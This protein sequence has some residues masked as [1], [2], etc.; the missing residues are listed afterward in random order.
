MPTSTPIASTKAA[1]CVATSRRALRDR[2]PLT[3]RT[4]LTTPAESSSDRSAMSGHRSRLIPAQAEPFCELL[5]VEAV[6]AT[7]DAGDPAPAHHRDP[8]RHRH[9]LI[10]VG[11]RDH[12]CDAVFLRATDEDISEIQACLDVEAASW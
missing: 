2:S 6:P 8:V 1:S 12:D 10:Q 4:R 5:R 11:G 9:K 3:R 7:L